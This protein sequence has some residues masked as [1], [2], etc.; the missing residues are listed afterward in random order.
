VRY[1]SIQRLSAKVAVTTILCAA[2]SQYENSNTGT[3]RPAERESWK[4]TIYEEKLF[5]WEWKRDVVYGVVVRAYVS[6]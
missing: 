5:W 6:I 3:W 2:W 4:E 1:K